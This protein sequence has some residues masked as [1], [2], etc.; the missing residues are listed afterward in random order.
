MPAGT[1]PTRGELCAGRRLRSCAQA[2]ALYSLA[3]GVFYSGPV[4]RLLL[5]TRRRSL[6]SV[7]RSSGLPDRLAGRL[8]RAPRVAEPGACSDFSGLLQRQRARGRA[9]YLP[10][11]VLSRDGASAS[12]RPSRAARPTG[13]RTSASAQV[14]TV[15]GRR[16]RPGVVWK[17]DRSA[18]R[19]GTTLAPAI[20]VGRTFHLWRDPLGFNPDAPGEEELAAHFANLCALRP[21]T[22]LTVA[23]GRIKRV[24]RLIGVD[25][26]RGEPHLIIAQLAGEKRQ[27]LTQYIPL[28]DAHNVTVRGLVGC[29]EGCAAT[30]EDDDY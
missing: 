10:A 9:R 4:R 19:E 8:G 29:V 22:T 1:G 25:H 5:E 24:G 23:S 6:G 14:G 21:G 7:A 27:A 2:V 26:S 17:H 12:V 16:V 11:V 18:A 15:L 3:C 13:G 20:T 30:L 28:R